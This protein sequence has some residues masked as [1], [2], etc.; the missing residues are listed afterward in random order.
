MERVIL[1]TLYNLPVFALYLGALYICIP[2]VAAEI[3]VNGKHFW[4]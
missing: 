1:Y 2:G 4:L 3:L